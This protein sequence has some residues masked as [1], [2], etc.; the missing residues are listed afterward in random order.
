M[1][2][3]FIL[4]T[5]TIACRSFFNCGT[6]SFWPDASAFASRFDFSNFSSASFCFKIAIPKTRCCPSMMRKSSTRFRGIRS[7]QAARKLLRSI[8]SNTQDDVLRGRSADVSVS[9]EIYASRKFSLA[10][11][12]PANKLA[13]PNYVHCPIKRSSLYSTLLSLRTCL[14]NTLFQW[15]SCAG[16]GSFDAPVPMPIAT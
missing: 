1:D 12:L 15:V 5:S 6:W 4:L 2:S 13:L 3:C 7:V 16:N 8:V 9:T 14:L 10:M 11:L